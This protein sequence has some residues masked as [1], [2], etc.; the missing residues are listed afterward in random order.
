MSKDVIENFGLLEVSSVFMHKK[1]IFIA[2]VDPSYL[3]LY[4][5]AKIMF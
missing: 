1:K 2:I 3:R 4:R 5:N